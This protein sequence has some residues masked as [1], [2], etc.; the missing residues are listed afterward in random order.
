MQKQARM[1]HGRPRAEPKA[2]RSNRVVTFVTD[3]ELD[4][5]EQMAYEEDRSL[6]AIVHRIVVQYL[7]HNSMNNNSKSNEKKRR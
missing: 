5:L 4:H 7:A 1:R 3:H 6:S 2:A